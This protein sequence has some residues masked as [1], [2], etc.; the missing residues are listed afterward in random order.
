MINV[1]I[2]MEL[3]GF[4]LDLGSFQ[5]KT[6]GH[7]NIIERVYSKVVFLFQTFSL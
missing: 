2:R 5:R 7:G 3:K 4:N 1:V 6:F